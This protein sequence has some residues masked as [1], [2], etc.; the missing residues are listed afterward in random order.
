M[1]ANNKE[2]TIPFPTVQQSVVDEPVSGMYHEC[3]F[4]LSQGTI[5][6]VIFA[7]SAVGI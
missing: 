2:Q 1:L 6:L 4:T 3:V 5:V 7:S